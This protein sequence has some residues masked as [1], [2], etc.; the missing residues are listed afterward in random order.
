MNSI[1]SVNKICNGDITI[2]ERIINDKEQRLIQNL[3]MNKYDYGQD[4]PL[5]KK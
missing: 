4:K 2:Y 5:I 3:M 1:I